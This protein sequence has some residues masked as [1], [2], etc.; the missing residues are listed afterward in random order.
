MLAVRSKN[1]ISLDFL[2]PVSGERLCNKQIEPGDPPTA[3]PGVPDP[4]GIRQGEH[5][6]VTSSLSYVK[7]R[8]TLELRT[9]ICM[10]KEE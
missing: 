3:A 7:L 2:R 4:I 8:V 6:Y 9:Y 5:C 10:H 1:N